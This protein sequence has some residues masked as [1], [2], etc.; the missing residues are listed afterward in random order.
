MQFVNNNGNTQC[1][2]VGSVKIIS[3]RHMC[4]VPGKHMYSILTVGGSW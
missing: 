1:S 3:L 2:E 4:E